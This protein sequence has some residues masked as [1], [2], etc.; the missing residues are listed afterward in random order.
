MF[1][2]QHL[3]WDVLMSPLLTALYRCSWPSLWNK[4]CC[5]AEVV[6]WPFAHSNSGCV[7]IHVSTLRLLHSPICC[8]VSVC[9]FIKRPT[10]EVCITTSARC[11]RSLLWK[12]FHSCVYLKL[13][14]EW[15][16]PEKWLLLIRSERIYM[17]YAPVLGVFMANSSGLY[18][19]LA[20]VCF[21]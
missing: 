17:C 4:L 11:Y 5:S 19:F 8:H 7:E 12:G 14:Q 21:N 6:L 1:K 3:G 15:C 20:F 9:R 10:N 13:D 16:V 2:F 18:F